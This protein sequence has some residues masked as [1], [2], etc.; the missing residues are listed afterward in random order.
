MI[1][2]GQQSGCLPHAWIYLCLPLPISSIKLSDVEENGYAPPDIKQPQH[3]PLTGFVYA[4]HVCWSPET[5]VTV[6]SYNELV[7]DFHTSAYLQFHGTVWFTQPFALMP[8]TMHVSSKSLSDVTNESHKWLG[9][10]VLGYSY[11]Y[12]LSLPLSTRTLA[13]KKHIKYEY[14]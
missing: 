7:E 1:K 4:F 5:A 3:I 12:L 8:N 9:A 2:T 11:I 10:H 14:L 13:F 6:H